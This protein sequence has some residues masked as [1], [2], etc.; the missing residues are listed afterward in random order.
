[1]VMSPGHTCVAAHRY[2]NFQGLLVTGGQVWTGV[3]IGLSSEGLLACVMS[4]RLC[5]D[6]WVAGGHWGSTVITVRRYKVVSGGWSGCARCDMVRNARSAC[7]VY[8]SPPTHL[9]HKHA[10][11]G[12]SRPPLTSVLTSHNGHHLLITHLD[13]SPLTTAPTPPHTHTITQYLNCQCNLQ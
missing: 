4:Q 12:E 13:K 10:G 7:H 5:G 11:S 8:M 1:M 9:S 2:I 6:C 3:T